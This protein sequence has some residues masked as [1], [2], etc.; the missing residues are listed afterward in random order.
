MKKT[1]NYFLLYIK[2]IMKKLI[3]YI[4]LFPG[5]IFI[6]SCTNQADTNEK[7]FL[8]DNW[9][10]QSSIEIVEDGETISSTGYE[11][12]GWYSTSVPATVL[13]VLVENGIYP[14]PYYGTNIESIPAFFL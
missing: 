2:N 9:A 12:D 1:L 11:P 6:L 4:F 8:K 7:F 13:A 3:I 14:D 5:I 10:I